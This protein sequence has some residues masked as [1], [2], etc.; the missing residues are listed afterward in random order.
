MSAVM[1]NNPSQSLTSPESSEQPVQ[2]PAG[3]LDIMSGLQKGAYMAL[4]ER[5]IL[6]VGGGLDNDIVLR[7]SGVGQRQVTLRIDQQSIQLHAVTGNAVIDG[8]V[9]TEGNSTEA[10]ATASVQI[11]AICLMISSALDSGNDHHVPDKQSPAPGEAIAQATDEI[12]G[13]LLR[14][15]PDENG[16]APRQTNPSNAGGTAQAQASPDTEVPDKAAGK[17]GILTLAAL[18][19][20]AVVVWQSGL[21]AGQEATSIS[22]SD[23]LSASEFNSLTV[24][25][26]GNSAVVNGFLDTIHES[27][28]LDQWLAQTGLLIDNKVIV[29]ESLGGQ[30]E[31]LFRVNG[32]KAL[33]KVSGSGV[34]T[35]T[36]QVADTEKLAVLKQRVQ[37]DVPAVRQLTINNTKPPVQAAE[38]E[39]YSKPDPG[40]RVSMVVSDKPAYV[41]TEDQSRYFK[42]SFL[43]SGH[44]ILS[45]EDGKVFLEKNGA[46]STLEF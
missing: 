7:D 21:F 37:A 45:I 26:T 9:L 42:G 31:D 43:P 46:K 4:P 13:N 34:V 18:L 30:V 35:A 16:L 28:L 17:Y 6:K 14:S 23:Q 24:V 27:V 39:Q 32:V 41:V 11:G 33:V 22:L 38:N 5:S 15:L 36:T 29:A 20:G 10:V 40:K 8:T 44:R 2:S 25:Q 19:L 12:S 1:E 3:K